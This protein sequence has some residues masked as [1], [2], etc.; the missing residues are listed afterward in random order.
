VTGFLAS[1]IVPVEVFRLFPIVIWVISTE[2]N[3]R[4]SM[5]FSTEYNVSIR[6]IPITILPP[7]FSL[8]SH[9]STISLVSPPVPPMNIASASGNSLIFSLAFPRITEMFSKLNF[10]IFF[11]VSS[12]AF[13][14]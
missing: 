1:I 11:L 9:N 5:V 3:F 8:F 10:V 2:V 4:F 12:T 7:D 13:A 6:I 14:S